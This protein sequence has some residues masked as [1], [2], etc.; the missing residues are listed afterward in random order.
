MKMPTL[1]KAIQEE[2]AQGHV[3]VVQLVST[4]EAMLDRRLA[5]MS[6]D[7][8]ATLDIDLSPREAI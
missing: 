1:L 6:A 3:A 4:S 7:E 2:L 8:R 5:A